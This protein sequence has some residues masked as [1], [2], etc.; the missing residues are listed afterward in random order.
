MGCTAQYLGQFIRPLHWS[1]CC[2]PRST[3]YRSRVDWDSAHLWHGRAQIWSGELQFSHRWRSLPFLS[4]SLILKRS[5]WHSQN[6]A[7][8]VT[9]NSRVCTQLNSRFK[10]SHLYSPSI[11][12]LTQSTIFP[13]PF[14]R[15][16]QSFY[17]RYVL[18]DKIYLG[19][20]SKWPYQDRFG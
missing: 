8:V 14:Q 11:Q 16:D 1:K 7:E 4:P 5:T 10:C 17:L 19:P 3:A 12:Y 2:Q 18:L 6:N 9:L 15:S 20:Y 13:S